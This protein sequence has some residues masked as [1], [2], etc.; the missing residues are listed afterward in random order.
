MPISPGRL[1]SSYWPGSVGGGA[2]DHLRSKVE[3]LEMRD[4]QQ[5]DESNVNEM[6]RYIADLE[7]LNQSLSEALKED[8][9]QLAELERHV[10]I[11]TEQIAHLQT[12]CIARALS[13]LEAEERSPGVPLITRTHAALSRTL[14][15]SPVPLSQRSTA[16]MPRKSSRPSRIYKKNS[17][18]ARPTCPPSRRR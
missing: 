3:L 9:H 17:M 16:Q 11:Q 2:V 10:E 14:K 5:Q 13:P 6:K 18:P 12:V 4:E 7:S 8:Q 15:R 1:I